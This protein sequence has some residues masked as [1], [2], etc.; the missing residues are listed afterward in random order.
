[1]NKDVAKV[2]GRCSQFAASGKTS[3]DPCLEL[4][5]G[6]RRRHTCTFTCIFPLLCLH[7]EIFVNKN[8][9]LCPLSNAHYV[10]VLFLCQRTRGPIRQ[11]ECLGLGAHCLSFL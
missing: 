10:D 2:V 9:V 5:P 11:D 8:F 7:L 6:L 1:M 3:E 4:L